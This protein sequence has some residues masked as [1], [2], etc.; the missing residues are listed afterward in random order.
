MAAA[1]DLW[2]SSG[3]E[4]NERRSHTG[5]RW[6]HQC[7]PIPTQTVKAGQRSSEKATLLA[8]QSIE[9]TRIATH[10]TA[11]NEGASLRI[12]ITRRLPA[13]NYEGFDVRQLVVGNEYDVMPR[14]ADLLIVSGY[15]RPALHLT[16]RPGNG[17]KGQGH[18]KS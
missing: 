13:R 10:Q 12:R 16:D 17:A 5:I 14:L 4:R 15:A 8:S 6:W 1:R 18:S 11:R 2:P 9:L 3:G 7:C